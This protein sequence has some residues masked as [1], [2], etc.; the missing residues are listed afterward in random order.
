MKKILTTALCAIM[1]AMCTTAVQA[2]KPSEKQ[3]MTREQMSEAQARNIAKE[4]KLDE[5]TTKKFVDT[6]SEYRKEMWA[7]RPNMKRP[8]KDEMDSEKA[9]KQRI[10]HQ[11]KMLDLREKYYDKYCKFLTAKQAER[12]F[13]LEQKGMKR[14]AK[15]GHGPG[16]QHGKGMKG[17]RFAPQGEAQ[18]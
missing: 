3:R 18:K 6:F 7:M 4:L 8:N 10:E 16:H 9:F 15:K 11:K 5:A 1:M 12:V 13:K 2:Q 14:L 17:R